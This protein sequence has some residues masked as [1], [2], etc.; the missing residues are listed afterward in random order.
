MLSRR[1]ME[2]RISEVDIDATFAQYLD[3]YEE[4]KNATKTANSLKLQARVERHKGNTLHE[5]RFTLLMQYL[6]MINIQLSKIYKKIVPEADCYLSYASNPISLFEEG[7]TLLAQYDR[8]AWRE[9]R[10]FLS[11]NH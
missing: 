10:S 1:Y 6:Q 9:V 11:E 5:T 7:V 2:K 4:Y 8:N 3:L